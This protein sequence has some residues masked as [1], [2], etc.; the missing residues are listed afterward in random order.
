MFLCIKEREIN[1]HLPFLFRFEMG[2]FESFLGK[3]EKFTKIK[4]SFY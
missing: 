4:K 1:K 2:L 3:T